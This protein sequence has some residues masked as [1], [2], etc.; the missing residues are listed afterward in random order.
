MS[1]ITTIGLDLAKHVFQVHGIDAQGTTVLRKRLR[2]GQVLVFF[3]RIPRC[4]IGLEACAAAHYWARELGALGHEVRLMPA[5]YVKAYIK[6]NR[7]DAADAEAICEAVGRP[8]MRFVPVK[9]AEQQATQLRH[10]GRAPA[11]DVG[12][13]VAGTSGGVRNDGGAGLAQCERAD[14]HCP[15]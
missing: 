13:C 2:R 12:E 10:R 3:S 14:R 15:R 7:H 5:Q 9:T 11:H 1:E 8:T 6:R 4:V